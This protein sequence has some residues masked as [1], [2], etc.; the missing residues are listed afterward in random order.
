MTG[1]LIGFQTLIEEEYSE[2]NYSLL[3]SQTYLLMYL[4]KSFEYIKNVI[5]K[6]YQSFPHFSQNYPLHLMDH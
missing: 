5:F 6:W 4:D 1:Q 3:C 2:P